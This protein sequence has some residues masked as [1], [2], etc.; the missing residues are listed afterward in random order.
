[1]DTLWLILCILL[2]IGGIAGCLLPI[3]PGPPLCFVA[4][5][6]LQ[7][8]SAPPFTTKFL[9]IW[10]LVTAVI[11]VVDYLI[12]SYSTKKFGGGKYGVWGCNI[13]LLIGIWLGPLGIIIGPFVGAFIGEMIATSD[14][15]VALKSAFG[16]FI[17]FLAGTVLKLSVCGVMAYYFIMGVWR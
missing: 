2:M 12:P 7:L 11:T 9:L 5:V 17:G 16:S 1:M 8:R 14:S 10:L 4:L 3:L 13:G 15:S 6:I